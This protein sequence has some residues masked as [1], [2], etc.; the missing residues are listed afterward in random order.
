MDYEWDEEK[1]SVTL[2]ERG[3]DFARA[4]KVFAG[5]NVQTEDDRHD[6]GEVRYITTGRYGRFV[7]IIVWTPRGEARRRIISMRKCD[8]EERADYYAQVD[9][10]G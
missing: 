10:S 8:A 2:R 6:Y 3:L 5:L 4:H 9:R 7:V 1:R